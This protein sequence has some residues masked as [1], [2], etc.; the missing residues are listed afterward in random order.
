MSVYTWVRGGTIAQGHRGN[1]QDWTKPWFLLSGEAASTQGKENGYS[2]HTQ[3]NSFS[4]DSAHRQVERPH[5]LPKV[6][7]VG[8]NVHKGENAG[9]LLNSVH[10]SGR[11][12]VDLEPLVKGET[13][14]PGPAA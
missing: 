14:I 8:L 5:R 13:G 4:D 6:P 10:G 11:C 9:R 2:C 3:A 12:R 7:K 1:Q